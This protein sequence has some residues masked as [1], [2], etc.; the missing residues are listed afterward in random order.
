MKRRK[1]FSPDGAEEIRRER[2]G[3][4]RRQE[5]E[6]AFYG[7]NGMNNEKNEFTYIINT[8]QNTAFNGNFL[9]DLANYRTLRWK[10]CRLDAIEDCAYEIADE[11]H[12]RLDRRQIHLAVI[13]DMYGFPYAMPKRLSGAEEE[14]DPKSYIAIYV[15]FIHYYLG[16]HLFNT[17]MD[18]GVRFC[19]QDVYYIQYAQ[20][21]GLTDIGTVDAAYMER[22][23]RLF[24]LPE[25]T[26][27]AAAIFRGDKTAS[28]PTTTYEEFVLPCGSE[29]NLRFRDEREARR[30]FEEY[31]NNFQDTGNE[32]RNNLY[33][34]QACY[35]P[36][37]AAYYA[38]A[39]SLYLVY[40]YEEEVLQEERMIFGSDGRSKGNF[41]PLEPDVSALRDLLSRSYNDI[42]VI[43]TDS[44]V[45][46]PQYYELKVDSS[47][48]TSQSAGRGVR[49]EAE[50]MAYA[51]KIAEEHGRGPDTLPFE[52][53]YRYIR[54]EAEAKNEDGELL[55]TEKE[56]MEAAMRDYFIGRDEMKDSG[57]K[58]LLR[59]QPNLTQYPQ[60]SD[61]N[62]AVNAKNEALREEMNKA[63][64]AE[65]FKP[66]VDDEYAAATEL[67]DK[68]AR[69]CAM[70]KGKRIADLICG[71]FAVALMIVGLVTLQF[72]H[73]D[74]VLKNLSAFSIGGGTF[75]GLY[76]LADLIAML[77]RKRKIRECENEMR[78]LYRTCLLKRFR[79]TEQLYLRY[80]TS[81]PKIEA[82]RYEIRYLD[83]IVEKNREVN[84][85][86][87]EHNKT[88]E[89]AEN[90]LREILGCMGENVRREAV[91]EDI[92][93][94]F[95]V[96]RSVQENEV[97]RILSI[98]NLKKIFR[99][100]NDRW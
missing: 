55:A 25:E 76:V 74:Q 97:Y 64:G 88:L 86:V 87:E 10:Q 93:P 47:I 1:S 9:F 92:R 99:G 34:A 4:L 8:S 40:H 53:Q 70:M 23:A 81:L 85:R 37:D 24:R 71:V 75:A 59:A 28:M 96:D 26:S 79:A 72:F 12:E 33:Y 78:T 91:A 73:N 7:V 65:Y 95:A 48:E 39:F 36:S 46:T 94:D 15:K 14:F 13:V 6:K 3:T 44:L 31:L 32:I 100:G 60:E 43:R 18:E 41:K 84:R 54:R 98:D 21:D 52:E 50:A 38:F 83:R 17:L 16:R 90:V 67:Y 30:T 45:N 82:L 77:P 80:S 63:F 89:E 22:T 27:A 62:K 20:A 68:H 66:N 61:Y 56:E 35:S 58:D 51:V 19:S 57:G 69:L 49:N 11:M 42:R 29:V 5:T 2:P